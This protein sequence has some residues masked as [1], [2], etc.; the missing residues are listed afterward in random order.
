MERGS[1]G[2]AALGPAS[3]NLLDPTQTNSAHSTGVCS[4]LVKPR[5]ACGADRRTTTDHAPPSPG[6]ILRPYTKLKSAL[7]VKEFALVTYFQAM[8]ARDD[9]FQVTYG[10]KMRVITGGKD[11]SFQNILISL[12]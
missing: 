5:P 4:P 7:I 3:Q 12:G 2:I 11:L 9:V 8:L 1:G 10:E 6:S